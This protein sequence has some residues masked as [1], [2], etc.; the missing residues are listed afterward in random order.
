MHW[1]ESAL[2]HALTHWG[3]WA[4]LLTLLC[5]SAG[6]PLPGETTLMLASFVAHKSGQLE[7]GWVVVVGIAAAITGDNVGFFLGRKLRGHLIRWWKK[8][9]RMDDTDIGA[10]REQIRR[11]GA[12][13]VFWARYVFGLRTVAGPLAGMLDMEWKR[14]FVFNVLGAATWVT[15]I[16]LCGYAFAYKFTNLL[17]YFEKASWVITV[18]LFAAGY[19]FWRRQKKKYKEQHPEPKAA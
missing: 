17:S 19:L 3:Y 16:S 18:A 7:I 14:F 2:R 8:I 9:F 15:A 13:T 6:L 12:A 11:H 4:V 10:A 5:E 1:I